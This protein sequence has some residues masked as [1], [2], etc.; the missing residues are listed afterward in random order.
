MRNII[1]DSY[2]TSNEI[3]YATINEKLMR[4]II[5]DSFTTSNEI[6]VKRIFNHTLKLIK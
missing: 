5:R 6:H 2:T 4:N 1:R 3:P